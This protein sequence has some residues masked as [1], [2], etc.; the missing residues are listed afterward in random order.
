MKH[1]AKRSQLLAGLIAFAAAFL[2][3]E[4]PVSGVTFPLGNR[5]TPSVFLE[6]RIPS[7]HPHL[8]K[9]EITAADSGL[10][11]EGAVILLFQSSR[12]FSRSA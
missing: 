11:I 12:A 10:N 3:A 1:A 8:S 9:E 7:D 4:I 2:L 6:Q 5:V